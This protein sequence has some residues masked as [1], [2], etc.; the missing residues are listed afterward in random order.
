MKTSVLTN[1]SRFSFTTS[2]SRSPAPNLPR[3]LWPEDRRPLHP[4]LRDTLF[5]FVSGKRI[6]GHNNQKRIWYFSFFWMPRPS[7]MWMSDFGRLMLAHWSITIMFGLRKS[8]K[9]KLIKT[10]DIPGFGAGYM[11]YPIIPFVHIQ[12]YSDSVGIAARRKIKKL[13]AK[14]AAL[15]PDV[16]PVLS[17]RDIEVIRVAREEAE[18]RQTPITT[19]KPKGDDPVNE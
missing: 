6:E 14:L 1:L 19:E 11:E 4:E 5:E 8:N 15:P 10:R 2:R 18:R 13:E 9:S 3:N 16:P 17:N 7:L 12:T